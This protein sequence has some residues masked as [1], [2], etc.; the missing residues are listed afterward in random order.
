MYTSNTS[1]YL[2]TIKTE[3]LVLPYYI[4]EKCSALINR[5]KTVRLK[6]I[7]ACIRQF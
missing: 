5:M 2:R 7:D 6:Y 1:V 4:T 3:Q